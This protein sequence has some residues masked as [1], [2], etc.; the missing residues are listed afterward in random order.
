MNL[1][2]SNEN[3]QYRNA[4]NYISTLNSNEQF[5]HVVTEEQL[6]FKDFIS[7]E[8]VK[9]KQYSHLVICYDIIKEAPQEFT[10]LL[11]YLQDKNNSEITI[12]FENYNDD[13]INHLSRI[14]IT[15]I[16]I[17]NNYHTLCRELSQSVFEGGI[18]HAV[19]EQNFLDGIKGFSTSKAKAKTQS[20]KAIIIFPCVIII[21]LVVLYFIRNNIK[22]P[23]QETGSSSSL[24]SPVTTVVAETTTY[25]VSIFAITTTTPEETTTNFSISTTA[26]NTTTTPPP[27]SNTYSKPVS[28]KNRTTTTPRDT[29]SIPKYTSK[30]KTT[31]K[32]TTT[33]RKTT[34]KKITTKPK[35]TTTKKKVTTKTAP[36]LKPIKLTGLKLS[37]AS[38]NNTV[39]IKVGESTH[40]K[41]VF[42]PAQATNKKVYWESNR[43]DRAVINNNGKVTGRSPGTV[44]I[45]CTSDDGRLTAACMV[46]VT[47]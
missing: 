25:N 38:P 34:T 15:N 46:V 32:K 19:L 31:V 5:R 9:L 35:V 42:I 16:I 2:I 8:S 36:T 3:E 37:T 30:K 39:Y 44:I 27:T 47:E 6:S 11:S 33:K 23:L 1:F 40:V 14:G 20:P 13:C 17:N 41:P 45:K 7:N 29:K 21:F 24:T 43:E 12:V 28:T 10:E 4:Y 22:Q 26:N 18:S